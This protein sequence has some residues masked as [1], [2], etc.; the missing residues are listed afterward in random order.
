MKHETD[1]PVTQQPRIEP[2]SEPR[3]T[4]LIVDHGRKNQREL[5]EALRGLELQ[6]L[7]ADNA[8]DA[9]R[10]LQDGPVDIVIAEEYLLGTTGSV[11]LETVLHLWPDVARVLIGQE[12]ASDA[13]TRAVNRARVHRVLHKT[14]A[15]H[16]LRA[17][18]EGALNELLF[19]RA[20]SATLPAPPVP[21]QPAIAP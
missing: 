3:F 18:V 1:P 9:L 6:V 11:L 5:S 2:P 16:S 20:R 10:I 19:S 14:M 8:T 4:C 7:A 21:G 12:L 15:V 13:L 17:E